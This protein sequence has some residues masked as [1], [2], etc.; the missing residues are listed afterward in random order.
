M[1]S[2]KLS[3]TTLLLCSGLATA[4]AAVPVMGAGLSRFVN[5]PPVVFGGSFISPNVELYGDVSIGNRSFI[6]GNTTVSAEPGTRVCIG[7]ETNLQDNILFL[8][9]RRLPFKAATGGCGG[10]ATTT[11]N[12]TSIAHQ[13]FIINSQLGNFVF[14]GFH[15]R[16]E[17]SVLE[18][19]VF[20]LHGALVKGVRV[21]KDRLVPTG[22]VITTQAQADAL[23]LKTE[24]NSAFQND[25]LE[26]NEEFAE[27][28]SALYENGG[29]D[30]VTGVSAGPRTSWNPAPVRPTLGTGVVIEEFVRVVGDVRLG[31]N[32]TVGRRTSVRADEGAPIIIG[33]DSRIQDRVTFHALKG[34]SITIG[35]GLNT[36]ENIVFH[37]P[38][39]AGDNLK[40]GHDAVV[41]RSK[42]GNNVTIGENALVIDV[43][44]PDGAVV[45]AGAR[46]LKQADADALKR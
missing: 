42:I 20:V 44:L 43:T 40:V 46:V 3:L 22:A 24:A 1:N 28:Y 2:F 32:S 31:A 41:F 34:T 38:L 35:K 36:A 26:V 7:N 45:P 21:A 16:V 9:Q 25:V 11:G 29:Y 37:G 23:P 18:D 19:G 30:A 10:R 27:G 12:R 4:K 5:A 14:V 15:S 39:T 6:A 17:S 13:A 33:A 8:A